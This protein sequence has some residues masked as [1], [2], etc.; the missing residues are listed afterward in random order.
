MVFLL[1]IQLIKPSNH[2]RAIQYFMVHS[3]TTKATRSSPRSFLS[4]MSR[5]STTITEGQSSLFFRCSP[6]PS[7]LC[8][9]IMVASLQKN[10]SRILH[11][12]VSPDI[13]NF[14]SAINAL[15]LKLGHNLSNIPRSML[16]KTN[17]LI[18]LLQSTKLSDLKTF[19][20][21]YLY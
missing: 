13:S 16:Y 2:S 14:L 17:S 3:L 6:T 7:V 19:D 10:L 15:V 5:S 21:S 9:R 11:P 8:T 4:N 12:L 20:Y 18:L 1:H